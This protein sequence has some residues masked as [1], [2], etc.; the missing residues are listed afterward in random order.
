MGFA[1]WLDDSVR[2]GRSGVDGAVSAFHSE[3]GSETL[4][5]AARTSLKV[6][7]AGV[8]VG[9]VAGYLS[10]KERDGGRSV[11]LALAGAALGVAGAMIWETRSLAGPVVREAARRVRSERDTLWLERNPVAYG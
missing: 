3:Q 9:A 10:S 7:A 6:A 11:A 4:S 8:L 1:Q 5:R 2:S